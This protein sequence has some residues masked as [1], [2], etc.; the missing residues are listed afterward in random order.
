MS[1]VKLIIKPFSRC[2]QK[3]SPNNGLVKSVSMNSDK[4]ILDRVSLDEHERAKD[5][6]H[7]NPNIDLAADSK[8]A[9]DINNDGVEREPYES[10]SIAADTN[11]LESKQMSEEHNSMPDESESHNEG[12]NTMLIQYL[13]PNNLFSTAF[14]SEK[15][16]DNGEDSEP[17][18]IINKRVSVVGVFDGMGGAGSAIHIYDKIEKTGAYFASR[19]VEQAADLYFTRLISTCDKT[20]EIVNVDANALKQEIVNALTLLREECPPKSKSGLKS[21]MIKE[22]PTTLA[23]TS[24]QKDIEGYDVTSLWAG[25]SRNYLITPEGLYQISVDDLEAHGDPYDNLTSDSPLSNQVCADREFTINQ[26]KYKLGNI[27]FAVFS[28]SDG[29]F[30]YYP[31]PMHFEE[32]ILR[33]LFNANTIADWKNLLQTEFAHIAADDTS[34]SCIICGFQSFDDFKFEMNERYAKLSDLI[35]EYNNNKRRIE[36]AKAIVAKCEE[37]FKTY[38]QEAWEQYKTNYMSYI[39]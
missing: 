16:P 24:I 31:T 37:E 21:A 7:D 25:D 39:S 28:A 18:L 29:C 6:E 30:G 27:G 5:S 10:P 8:R 13:S 20:A 36:E 4:N 38:K 11:G 32:A 2:G 19:R 3:N 15:K 12:A 23:I 33:N 26:S 14:M 1:I 34:F 9:S 17:L 22:F 35:E